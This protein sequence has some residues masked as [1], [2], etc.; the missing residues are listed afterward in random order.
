MDPNSILKELR[1][2]R[3]KLTKAIEA[4]EKLATSPSKPRGRPRLKGLQTEKSQSPAAP[5][6]SPS[7]S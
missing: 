6:A 4:L 1:L 5:V 2:Q 7:D 3:D